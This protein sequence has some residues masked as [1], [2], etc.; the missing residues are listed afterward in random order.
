VST[1]DQD[2]IEAVCA[3]L[4]TADDGHASTKELM[5]PVPGRKRKP[6]KNVRWRYRGPEKDAGVRKVEPTGPKW[7][8]EEALKRMRFGPR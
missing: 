6:P 4:L 5:T 2:L 8:R 1:K 3:V 7:D